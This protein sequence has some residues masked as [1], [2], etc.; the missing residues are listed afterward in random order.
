MYLS[1]ASRSKPDVWTKVSPTVRDKYQMFLD[2]HIRD[3]MT[4]KQCTAVMNKRP[5][6][7]IRNGSCKKKNTFILDSQKAVIEVCGR[8]G[9]RYK[10][11]SHRGLKE[12]LRKFHIVDCTSCS[13]RRGKH[14]ICQYRGLDHYMY[15]VIKCE[16]GLPVHFERSLCANMTAFEH[17]H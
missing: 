15:I 14:P 16:N 1:W 3:Q 4:A 17:F 8:Q 9:K 7:F 10:L 13:R 5:D 2:R 11:K 12:S 6:L